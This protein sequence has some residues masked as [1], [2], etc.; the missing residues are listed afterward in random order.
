MFEFRAQNPDTKYRTRGDPPPFAGRQHVADLGPAYMYKCKLQVFY[1][2]QV[3]ERWMNERLYESELCRQRSIFAVD[4]VRGAL[5]D[6][7][8]CILDRFGLKI[9]L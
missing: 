4:G 7:R 3:E 2:V 1:L 8:T 6:F 5:S 9:I